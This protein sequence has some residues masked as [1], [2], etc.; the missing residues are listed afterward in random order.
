[1]CLSPEAGAYDELKSAAI[2]V[3]PYDVEQCAAALDTAL[4]MPLDER[5]NMARR[6]RKLA[7]ARTPADWLGDLVGHAS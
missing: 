4:A 3:H 2:A 1:L 7:T 5:A 6:L